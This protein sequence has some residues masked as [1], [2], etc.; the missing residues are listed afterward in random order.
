MSEFL[1]KLLQD[2][3]TNWQKWFHHCYGSGAGHDFG[4]AHY[5]D[6]AIWSALRQLLPEFRPVPRCT[7]TQAMAR[8]TAFGLIAGLVTSP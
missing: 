7:C 6:T 4:D 3:I 8:W 1:S 5:L 2:P